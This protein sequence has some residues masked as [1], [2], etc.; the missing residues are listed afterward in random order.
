M[1]NKISTP[2][3]D[4]L[5]AYSAKEESRFHMPGHKGKAFLGIEQLDITEVPGA[6]S[7]YE[8]DGI[9]KESEQN[10]T[11]LFDTAR[12][13]Y[14]TG[15]SSQCIGAMLYMALVHYNQKKTGQKPVVIAARNVHKAFIHAAAL[16]DFDVVWLWPD[17]H[18]DSICACPISVSQV[19]NA[20]KECD[21]RVMSVYLTSP[22][23][24]GGMQDIQAIA[25]VCHQYNTLLTVDNAHGAYLHFLKEHL[26]PI[27]MGADLT[28]DSAHKTL[29]VLTGG[30]YLHISKTAPNDLANQ[31][32]YALSLFGSTSPSYLTMA[33]LDL[34]N[35][36]LSDSY[37][38]KLEEVIHTILKCK[39][40]LRLNG[41][42]V[43]ETEPLKLV[44]KIP[45]NNAANIEE[46]LNSHNVVWEYMD[47]DY[48]VFMIT[49]ENTTEEI[50]RISLALG[51]NHLEYLNHEKPMI[52]PTKQVMSIRSAYFSPGEEVD[53]DSAYGRICRVPTV[54]CPPAIP[55]AVPGEYITEEMIEVFRHYGVTKIDVL[56]NEWSYS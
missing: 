22:D 26:H 38:S 41:Y 46:K 56:K 35:K 37:D 21:G 24:L 51:E 16:L 30:A 6:D 10:A 14:A 19:E 40:A 2:I 4:F 18:N 55:I 48:V 47:Q 50:T 43:L 53:A 54:S 3:Y 11:S 42:E 31:A 17:T 25:D 23:Y 1:I 33:S 44:C 32:K 29:P 34:C 13:C 20:L 39:N 36:Y 28:S 8:A 7:L 5:K 9:I 52:S 15:G 12:T 49:P 27:D 45:T